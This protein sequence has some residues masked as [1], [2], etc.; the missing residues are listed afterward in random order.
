MK[1]AVQSFFSQNSIHFKIFLLK[2]CECIFGCN[3][4]HDTTKIPLK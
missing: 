1:S 4:K 2:N 3:K